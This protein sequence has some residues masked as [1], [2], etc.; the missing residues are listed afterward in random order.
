M[1]IKWILLTFLIFGLSG[2]GYKSIYSSSEANFNI[3]KIE[4]IED[5]RLNKKILNRLEVYSDPK[6]NNIINIRI[7]SNKAI[8]VVSKDARGNPKIFNMTISVA[9]EILKDGSVVQNKNFIESFAYENTS[10]K[11]ELNQYEKNI[12]LNLLDEIIENIVLYL[13]TS[14]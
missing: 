6:S 3:K 12:Q 10:K 4:I 2:C 14:Y 13:Q 7:N 11:F 5:S 9:I 1:K 8:S